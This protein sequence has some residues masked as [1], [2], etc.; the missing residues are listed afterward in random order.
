MSHNTTSGCEKVQHPLTNPTGSTGGSV[1]LWP[2][3]S[4]DLTCV[5]FFFF[6]QIKAMTY[7]SP[8]E[9]NE[10]LVDSPPIVAGNVS[11]MLEILVSVRQSMIR[12]CE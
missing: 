7:P 6:G 8:I 10:N 2:L 12:S 9:T 5:D 11:E 1:V 3:R 4:S